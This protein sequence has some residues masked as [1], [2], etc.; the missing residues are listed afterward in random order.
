MSLYRCVIAVQK[1]KSLPD[2]IAAPY[3]D[4]LCYR[5]HNMIDRLHSAMAQRNY[6]WQ[7]CS[8]EVYHQKKEDE[9]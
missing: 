9:K 3:T 4:V 5:Q 6:I 8:G 7:R 1:C 2:R